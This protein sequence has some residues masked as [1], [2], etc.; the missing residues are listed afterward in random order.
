L[1]RRAKDRVK[2]GHGWRCLPPVQR[3]V[4]CTVKFPLDERADRGN[5]WAFVEFVPRPF[6][7][8]QIVNRTAHHRVVDS[9]IQQAAEFDRD[10]TSPGLDPTHRQ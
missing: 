6:G 4:V 3:N 1:E 5:R 10:H 7:L 8:D 2:V 9:E